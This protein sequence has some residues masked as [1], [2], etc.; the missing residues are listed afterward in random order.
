MS[1]NEYDRYLSTEP[2]KEELFDEL[3]ETL[4]ELSATEDDGYRCFLNQKLDYLVAWGDKQDYEI[5]SVLD[6]DES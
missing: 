1:K 2:S 6:G 4:E 5:F 3:E